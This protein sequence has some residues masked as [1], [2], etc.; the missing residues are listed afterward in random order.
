MG[1]ILRLDTETTD[2]YAPQIIL[3]DKIESKGSL[4]LFD[5]NHKLGNTTDPISRVGDALPNILDDRAADLL[6]AGD[7]RFTVLA[8][9][10]DSNLFK[11]ERTAK[12]GL[13]GI[14]TQSGAQTSSQS[15][16]IQAA[17]AIKNYVLANL[18]HK[19]Y[20]SLWTRVVRQ[21][22]LAGTGQSPFHFV[23]GSG[24]ST[25]NYLWNYENGE[26]RPLSGATLLG[27]KSEPA[28]GDVSSQLLPVPYNRFGVVGV[29]GV[30]GSGPAA[31]DG[32]HMVLGTQGPWNGP[33]YN[34]AA[35]RI[36]YRAYVEDLTVSGRSYAE[37]EA[38][39]YALYQEAF[40]PGG[41]FHGDIYLD[42]AS[43]P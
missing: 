40:A 9:S 20:V 39:D 34:K 2:P 13:Y 10:P 38:I 18:S 37:V 7:Y 22:L 35:S 27:R 43:L 31:A 33:N 26:A 41:K 3:R 29:S 36:I 28:N 5:G 15:V 12:G 8:R 30:V 24:S 14:V 21:S 19:F 6:G 4:F 32:I 23:N 42:P 25:A 11:A 1:K 17:P 16:V